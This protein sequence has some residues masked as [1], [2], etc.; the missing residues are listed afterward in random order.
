M[1]VID[2]NDIDAA[3]DPGEHLSQ[4]RADPGFVGVD[5]D[6]DAHGGDCNRGDGGMKDWGAG[7]RTED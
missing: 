6:E 3:L 7:L 2:A 1:I 5:D 4:R